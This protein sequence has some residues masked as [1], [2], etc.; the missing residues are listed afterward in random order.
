MTCPIEKTL[1]NGPPSQ[2]ISRINH[3]GN[4][5]KNLPTNDLDSITNYSMLYRHGNDVLHTSGIFWPNA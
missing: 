4:L 2:L 3:L 5:W 1:Q